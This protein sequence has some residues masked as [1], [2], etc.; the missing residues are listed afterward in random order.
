MNHTQ[1]HKHP[2]RETKARHPT[3][4]RPVITRNF[5]LKVTKKRLALRARAPHYKWPIALIDTVL[6]LRHCHFEKSS[7]HRFIWVAVR[8]P[9]SAHEAERSV[10]IYRPSDTVYSAWV[11]Q[12]LDRRILSHDKCCK[13]C[14]CF[15]GG[16]KR[17]MASRF[18]TK[19]TH[20]S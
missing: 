5:P 10:P 3:L 13:S 12:C 18:M 19:K 8:C 4:V 16:E 1:T 6:H 9:Q 17:K 15:L 7:A 11:T 2:Y 20:E 14:S